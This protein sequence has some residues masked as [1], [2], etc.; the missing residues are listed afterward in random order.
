MYI[1]RGLVCIMVSSN[2]PVLCLHN[3]PE[4][5]LRNQEE[6]AHDRSLAEAPHSLAAALR[7]QAGLGGA[8]RVHSLERTYNGHHKICMYRHPSVHRSTPTDQQG[9]EQP[10]TV[11]SRTDQ[12]GAGC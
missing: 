5:A 2:L 7:N 10:R 12:Q 1:E 11:D 8:V 6:V 3:Q 9:L 4:A